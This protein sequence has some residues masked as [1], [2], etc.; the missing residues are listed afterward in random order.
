MSSDAE[1]VVV[2][3]GVTGVA[4]ARALARD[5]CRTL[6][7]EQH[8]L[9]HH[10]GSSH[11]ASRIFRLAYPD[12]RY[13]SLAR[14]AQRG[15]LELEAGIG[16]P[17][18]IRT[19]SLDV[20][21]LAI[22]NASALEACGIRFELLDGRTA[23][24][25]WP[26]TL[27]PHEHVLFHPDGGTMLADRAIEALLAEAREA[28]AELLEQTR[29]TELRAD[30]D[31]IGLQ[32]GDDVVKA[33]AVVVAAGAWARQL[34]APLGYEL[35]VVATRETVSYFDL[36]GASELPTVIDYSL[37]PPGPID[38]M[39]ASYGLAA[40]GI[41]LK[42]GLHRG[43]S[44]TDPDLLGEPEPALV[45]WTQEWVA[46]RFPDADPTPLSSETCIYTNTA[47]QSFVIERFGRIVVASACSGHGFKFAPVHGDLIAALVAEAVDSPSY[48]SR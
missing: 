22:E 7:V 32:I 38:G 24:R 19:G 21:D 41:G 25:R 33:H 3:A 23:A 27:A 11:G 40:P 43:G 31:A 5:G 13:V 36:P 39:Q 46:R 9:G 37:L 26:I 6:L 20:G 35:D 44:P 12:A 17:L 18:V 34:L 45:E 4:A 14:E 48:S 47:D 42:A 10:H 29:V 16:S 15:W 8:E 28:G 1:V 30:R 2:G